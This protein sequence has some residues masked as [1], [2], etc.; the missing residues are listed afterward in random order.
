[1]RNPK[2]LRGLGA[3]YSHPLLALLIAAIA[4]VG[5]IA[6]SG[7]LL[8]EAAT[9]PRAASAPGSGVADSAATIGERSRMATAP[10]ND[11]L[12]ATPRPN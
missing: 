7:L 2:G 11:P 9:G 5:A 1:M 4:A 12:P 10:N 8:D 6:Q 3:R